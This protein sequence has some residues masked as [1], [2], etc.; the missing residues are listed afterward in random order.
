MS[1]AAYATGNAKF[2]GNNGE[3]IL[4]STER[5]TS[6]DAA[7]ATESKTII[8]GRTLTAVEAGEAGN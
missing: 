3:V 1:R 2:T 7:N 5:E 4:A 6:D 8:D